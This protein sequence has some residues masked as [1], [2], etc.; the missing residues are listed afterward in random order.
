MEKKRY[1][2][3][4]ADLEAHLNK[5]G[6]TSA[7]ASSEMGFSNNYLCV[8]YKKGYLQPY[9]VRLIKAR[10]GLDYEQY[11]KHEPTKSEEPKETE[12]A[13]DYTQDLILEELRSIRALLQ[14]L[15]E[16]LL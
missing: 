10:F 16:A 12:V 3:C 2:I 7:Q 4:R 14:S 13:E 8:A 11:K 6:V 5:I 1:E 15:T 9:A